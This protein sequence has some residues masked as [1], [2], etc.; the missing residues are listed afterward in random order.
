MEALQENSRE[1]EKFFTGVLWLNAKAVG[2]AL[3]LICGL[4]IFLATN[5][6]ILKGGHPVGPHLSLLNQFFLGYRVTFLGSLVGFAYG[7]AVGTI[8][9]AFISWIYNKIAGLKNKESRPGGTGF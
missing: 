5:W 9:G 2:L 1:T 4:G 8:S 7:F 3:G 6:L